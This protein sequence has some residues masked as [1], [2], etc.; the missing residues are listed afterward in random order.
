MVIEHQPSAWTQ[1]SGNRWMVQRNAELSAS[2]C[3]QDVA[4][5][6][7]KS[8]RSSKNHTSVCLVSVSTE[9]WNRLLSEWLYDNFREKEVELT[10][11]KNQSKKPHA[12][13]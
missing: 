4:G 8:C 13:L 7:S 3:I 6:M 5:K 2:E 9:F 12:P 10:I 11:L 1:A